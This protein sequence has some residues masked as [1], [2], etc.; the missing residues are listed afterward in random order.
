MGISGFACWG[1]VKIFTNAN[2]IKKKE[3]EM[4]YFNSDYLEGA[5]PKIL[6]KL[7]ETNMEKTEGYGTDCYCESAKQKIR[8]ACNCPEAEIFF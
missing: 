6:Q 3:Y 8:V 5:H 1:G 2:F 7:L 4:Q